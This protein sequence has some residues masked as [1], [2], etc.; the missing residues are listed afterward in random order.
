MMILKKNATETSTYAD[1]RGEVS[2][3]LRISFKTLQEKVLLYTF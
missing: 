2:S 1:G 3:L